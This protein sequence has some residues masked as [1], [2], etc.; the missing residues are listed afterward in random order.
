MHN[1]EKHTDWKKVFSGKR[2]LMADDDELNLAI[3]G[4]LL[5][6]QGAEV[7]TVRDGREAL[8]TYRAEHGVFDLIIMDIVMPDLSGLEVVRRIRRTHLY[9]G[10]KTIPIV[11][12]TVN[13]SEEDREK[14]LAAGMNAHLV[15]PVSPD[16]FFPALEKLLEAGQ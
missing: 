15:K 10:A 4:N 6:E 7:H 9:P 12:L 16:T 14:S 1:M 13:S 11:A 5:R 3:I 8:Y 2:I